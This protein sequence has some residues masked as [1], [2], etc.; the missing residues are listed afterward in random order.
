MSE[1]PS[2]YVNLNGKCLTLGLDLFVMNP[3]NFDFQYLINDNE[4]N[5]ELIIS[6]PVRLSISV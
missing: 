1:T 4:D 3:E 6:G 2:K 5:N